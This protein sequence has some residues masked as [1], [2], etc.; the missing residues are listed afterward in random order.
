[1]KR[2]GCKFFTRETTA[3]TSKLNLFAFGFAPVSLLISSIHTIHASPKSTGVCCKIE[4]SSLRLKFSCIAFLVAAM[5]FASDFIEIIVCTSLF[6]SMPNHGSS[7]LHEPLFSVSFFSL[8][9]PCEI[10]KTVLFELSSPKN[11]LALSIFFRALSFS[12]MRSPKFIFFD[13]ARP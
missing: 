11:S 2:F 13:P 7:S 3:S 1:M 12:S 6:S 5:R 4:R 8:S 10:S 9:S